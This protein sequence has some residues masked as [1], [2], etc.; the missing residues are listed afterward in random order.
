ME[1][2][3]EYYTRNFPSDELGEELN[4]TATFDTLLIILF[5]RKD[6]YKY[7]GVGDS[8]IRERIFERLAEIKGIS[9]N[10]VYYQW[11]LDPII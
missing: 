1:T 5:T 7:I 9:Y 10:D 8:I 11:M 4:D 2:I 3:K 6:V